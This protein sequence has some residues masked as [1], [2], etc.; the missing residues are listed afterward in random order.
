MS[1]SASPSAGFPKLVK[2]TPVMPEHSKRSADTQ[3][4]KGAR[5]LESQVF[6]RQCPSFV[7]YSNCS[8]RIP[9]EKCHCKK[10]SDIIIVAK[11]FW[12]A[13]RFK[14]GSCELD[15]QSF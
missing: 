5:L 6:T 11:Y 13:Y 12:G 3:K 15:H 7:G 9:P 14:C 8:F 1:E 2:L 10:L 4:V